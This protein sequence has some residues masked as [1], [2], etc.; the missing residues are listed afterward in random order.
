MK[1][2]HDDDEKL[3]DW[4]RERYADKYRWVREI[5]GA[6]DI[7]TGCLAFGVEYLGDDNWKVSFYWG[8]EPYNDIFPNRNLVGTDEEVKQQVDDFI[9][10]MDKLKAF[11]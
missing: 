5:I 4:Y 8:L 6:N 7:A 10:R 2:L 11:L 1:M 3:G 9:V